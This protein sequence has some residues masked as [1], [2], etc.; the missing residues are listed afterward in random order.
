MSRAVIRTK[1]Q[2]TLPRDIRDALHVDEGDDISFVV[3]D[4]GV[5]TRTRLSPWDGERFR[6][7]VTKLQLSRRAIRELCP[8]DG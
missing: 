6:Q 7:M 3:T 8:G 5:L 1:G 2:I 4:E